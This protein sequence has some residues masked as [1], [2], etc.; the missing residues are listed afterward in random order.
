MN[1]NLKFISSNIFQSSIL[2]KANISTN[3]K[4]FLKTDNPKVL[5][6]SDISCESKFLGTVKTKNT[7]LNTLSKNFYP[8]LTRGN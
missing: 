5:F 4:D 3:E 7:E 8:P 1:Q 2:I 6:I